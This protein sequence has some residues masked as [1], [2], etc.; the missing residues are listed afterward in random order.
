MCN[1][2]FKIMKINLSCITN[3]L[4]FFI[5]VFGFV[6]DVSAEVCSRCGK[7]IIGGNLGMSTHI[8]KPRKRNSMPKISYYSSEKQKDSKQ[9]PSHY[10]NCKNA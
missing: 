4:I 9:V 2:E 1:I 3:F 10:F 5:V 6:G 8:C 7:N